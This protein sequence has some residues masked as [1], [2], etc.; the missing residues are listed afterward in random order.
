[1]TVLYDDILSAEKYKQVEVLEIK[2]KKINQPTNIWLDHEIYNCII[3]MK[4]VTID[5]F[6]ET[7][8]QE[9]KRQITCMMMIVYSLLVMTNSKH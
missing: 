8:V 5:H 6:L 3:L 9:I 2:L 4:G 1:M 7:N